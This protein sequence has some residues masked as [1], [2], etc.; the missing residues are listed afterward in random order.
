[1]A[2]LRK[3]WLLTELPN[4]ARFWILAGD[5]YVSRWIVSGEYE[6]RETA[7]VRRHLKKGMHALDVGANL[8]WF[9]VNMAFLVGPGGR[10]DA[11]EPREDFALHLERTVLENRLS[12]VV[13]HKYALS[14]TNG[15][16]L[17]SFDEEGLNPG[18]TYLQV[19]ETPPWDV[20]LK[21]QVRRMD[22]VVWAPV[23]FIKIDVEGAEKLV[24]DGAGPIL[25]R[26][27]PIILSEINHDNLMRTSR[28]SGADYIR[29]LEERGYVMTDI[30]P[31]GRCGGRVSP[32]QV[33][34]STDVLNLACLP[35]DKS[36]EII[37]R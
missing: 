7:F 16:G 29:Y 37:Q 2:G 17:I 32:A 20:S 5:E 19:G 31:D 6:P 1:M 22:S 8:G 14:A 36:M 33:Q 21:I 13:I 23:D 27:R 18:G 30:L 24:L 12:N 11:F 3:S 10:V 26:D 15:E 28:I 9:T 4:G 25:D 34:A 35:E